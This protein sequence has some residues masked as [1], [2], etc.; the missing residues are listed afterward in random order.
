MLFTTSWD[1]GDKL[2][3]KLAALLD[4]YGCKATLYICPKTCTLS[5]DQIRELT[6]RHEIGAHSMAHPH[7]SAIPQAEA[8][9]EIAGSK[10]WVEEIIHQECR[11]FCYPFGD[12][13]ADVRS[14][15]R[16]EG[17]VGARTVEQLNWNMGDP[18]G[19]PTT[20]QVYPYPWRRRWTRRQH[21]LDPLDRLRFLYPTL[22]TLHLPLR[23]YTGWLALAK[24]LFIHTQKTGK[25]FFHLWGH[26]WEV[27]RYRMWGSLERFLAFVQAQ[28]SVEHV[29]NS[30]LL[31]YPTCSPLSLRSS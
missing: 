15:V 10:R 9:K 31:H 22:K 29:R 18:F 28:N 24:A 21:L 20:L 12:E 23:A 8:R 7:L 16:E 2:D 4:R 1:D 14:L 27:E 6:A 3:C 13:N 30:E 17:F 11:V 25:P 5:Q 19:M 26:S